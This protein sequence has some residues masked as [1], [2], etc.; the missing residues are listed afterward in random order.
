[1]ELLKEKITITLRHGAHIERATLSNIEKRGHPDSR[2]MLKELLITT[3]SA[4]ESCVDME[5]YNET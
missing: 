4:Y 2:R 5:R 3:K 1:M